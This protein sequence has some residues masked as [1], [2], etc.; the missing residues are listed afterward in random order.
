M[1]YPEY[2][3]HYPHAQIELG[4][5]GYVKM[6]LPPRVLYLENGEPVS[7]KDLSRRGENKRKKILKKKNWL[8]AIF[9][10]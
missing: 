4:Q 6:W 8:S 3:F 2:R 5:I 9:Q 7:M 10:K 1:D